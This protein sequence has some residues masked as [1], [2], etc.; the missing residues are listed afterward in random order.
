ML[1]FTP[2]SYLPDH[3]QAK[4][5]K[6][7]RQKKQER[8]MRKHRVKHESGRSTKALW[9]RLVEQSQKLRKKNAGISK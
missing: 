7:N 9:V 1:K 3:K 2:M 5:K 6:L 8:E 4:V